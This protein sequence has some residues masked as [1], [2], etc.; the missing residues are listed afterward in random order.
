M[1]SSQRSVQQPPFVYACSHVQSKLTPK[2]CWSSW[3]RMKNTFP[4]RRLQIFFLNRCPDTSATGCSV[5][6]TVQLQTS[7]EGR[8]HVISCLLCL[9]L[10][11]GNSAQS[12]HD[13]HGHQKH[14]LHKVRD[15]EGFSLLTTQSFDLE[16]AEHLNE[17][18]LKEKLGFFDRSGSKLPTHAQPRK[19]S[20]TT[21]AAAAAR[22][23]LEAFP[24]EYFIRV[25]SLTRPG[26]QY[27]RGHGCEIHSQPI[28]TTVTTM[29]LRCR[30]RRS[31][32]HHHRHHHHSLRRSLRLRKIRRSR[33]QK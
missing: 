21:S 27:P 14:C 33:K 17:D 28:S 15:Y 23:K 6:L 10:P 2:P 18:W 32:H 1:E 3:I 26:T 19:L 4:S 29:F 25:M 7:L 12:G 8:T 20:L 13:V 5:F 31:R 11:S 16:D 24:K 9:L 22:F 30:R